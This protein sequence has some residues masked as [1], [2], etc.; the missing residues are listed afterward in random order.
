M[1]ALWNNIF[2]G[3][4]RK[5]DDD[6]GGG[7]GG[8]DDASPKGLVAGLE[9]FIN[10]NPDATATSKGG[11]KAQGSGGDD[12]DDGGAMGDPIP[13]ITN[14]DDDDNDEPIVKSIADDDDGDIDDFGLPDI[15]GK[16]GDEPAAK[17]P[18]FDEA[19]FD[20]ETATILKSI[21]DKG[22]PG[23]VYKDLRLKL[24]DYEKSTAVAPELQSKLDALETKNRELEEKAARVEAME[25]KVK[26]VTS[27]NAELLLEESDEYQSKVA[28]PHTEISK[29]VTALSEAKG[30]AEIELWAAI[31]ENDP[32]KRMSMID[33]LESKIGGRHALTVQ[34][35]ANDIRVIARTDQAMRADAENII[36]QSKQRDTEAQNSFSKERVGEFQSAAREAFTRYADRIPEF[37]DDSKLMTDAAKSAQAKALNVDVANLSP[38]DMGY[39]VFSTQALPS[40]LRELK[41]LQSENRDLRV[42][43]GDRAKDIAPGSSRKKAAEPSK[44]IDPATQKPRTFMEG[45]MN[46]DFSSG[47]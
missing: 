16:T 22:H 37:V 46:E 26:K 12:G 39:M 6:G 42:A 44:H 4:L 19:A 41:R 11:Q 30:V 29:T 21:E 36:N 35:M 24:K 23:D 9:G 32:V 43:A 33:A 25:E 3:G 2:M 10:D 34:N 14:D 45:F 28:V 8:H 15:G 20:A 40:A 27:R 1:K 31:K 7:G 47:V 17:K 5:P 38:G 18:G 13:G